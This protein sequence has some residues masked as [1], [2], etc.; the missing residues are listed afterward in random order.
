MRILT[1]TIAL[2]FACSLL[3]AG[4]DSLSLS[5]E[6]E[7]PS[8]DV[9][10]DAGLTKSFLNSVYS[11]TGH[12]Y[13]SPSFAAMADDAQNPKDDGNSII[14]RSP[15]TPSDRRK[16]HGGGTMSKFQWEHVYSQGRD[17][18]IFLRNVE[19]S[20]VISADVRETLRGE[21]YFLRAWFHSS[22]LR[23]YGGV[24]T[25]DNT[26]ELSEDISATQ[27]PRSS[28]QETVNFVISDLDS[29]LALLPNQPRAKGTATTGAARA[30]KCRIRVHAASDLF[31]ESPFS[32]TEAA[33]FVSY[34][35]G[36]QQD[37]WQTAA[38]ACQDV[39]DMNAYSLEQVNSAEGYHELFTK[40]NG[41]GTI[42]AR[43]FSEAG[44]GAHD[45]SLWYSP[46]G[47]RGWY[48]FCWEP[49]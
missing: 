35:G 49:W 10:S 28:F 8:E 17:L 41:S 14:W 22:L 39:I 29:A 20:E 38:S 42:W 33:E 9:W 4:C 23:A 34:T 37:R 1:R 44:G 24:P 40:G 32:G 15:P 5:P 18:N 7:L 21:A 2:L 36:S 47:W 30:L 43:Y 45:I 13:S 19:Q 3:L 12:G 6:S 25:I 26:F 46:N 27:V 11:E 48:S 16:R 31:H